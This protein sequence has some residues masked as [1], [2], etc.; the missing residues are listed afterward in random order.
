MEIEEGYLVVV[1]VEEDKTPKEFPCDLGKLTDFFQA[2]LRGRLLQ[3]HTPQS[4][5]DDQMTCHP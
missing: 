1:M 4:S 3:G 2:L 5:C